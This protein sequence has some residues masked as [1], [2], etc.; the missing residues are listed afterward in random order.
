MG[1]VYLAQD[2]VTGLFFADFGNDLILKEIILGTRCTRKS[3]IVRELG[4]VVRNVQWI[5]AR[6]AFRS[7]R[8]VS[9]Q[10]GVRHKP[11]HR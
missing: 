2:P 11:R 7:F 3:G 4:S 1:V 8:V 6:L 5:R 10:R 9:D